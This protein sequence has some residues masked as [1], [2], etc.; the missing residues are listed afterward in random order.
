MKQLL[1]PV[2]A[3]GLMTASATA[4]TAPAMAQQAQGV[5]VVNIPAV[6]A[7]SNAYQ[8]A[9]QQRQTTYAAQIQQAET[10]QQQISAQLKPLVDKFNADRQAATP[11]RASLQQQAGQI[12]QIEQAGQRELQQILAPVVASQTYVNE[13][14]EDRLDE[15]V[16]AAAT[17]NN[18]TL[19]LSASN[20][21][22]LFAGPTHNLN[23]QVLAELN[24][25]LPAAALV[26]PQGWL[27]REIRQQ[28]AAQAAAQAQQA[29]TAPA[30]PAQQQPTGR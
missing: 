25:L 14:I 18:V 7:N 20:G 2:L 10:R 6:V 28:Q 29:G 8:T 1:K 26:P 19:V 21:Q 24:T 22:I 27:P 11:D 12:Q 30:A 4:I 23:Q 5:A 17:K 15:A 3:L 16:Q 13:Q 9:Q